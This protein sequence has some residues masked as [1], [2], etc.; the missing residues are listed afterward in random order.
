MEQETGIPTASSLSAILEVLE[1]L[2]LKKLVIVSPYRKEMHAAE[3]RF[4]QSNGFDLIRSRS[5]GLDAG[6]K[7]ARV[8][9]AEIY[10]FCRETWD[11][12]A[13]GLFI[14]CMNF[15]AMPCI[16]PLEKD[17]Q[18]PVLTSHSSALWKGLTMVHV[19]ESISGFGRLLKEGL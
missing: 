5:M 9:P 16:G 12:R 8:P 2:K 13:D 11:E 7:F 18:K 4:F 19:K 14:S 15:N 1:I 6:V 3:E 17:L 10:R